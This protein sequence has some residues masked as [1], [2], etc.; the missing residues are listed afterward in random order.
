MGTIGGGGGGSGYVGG[1]AVSGTTTTGNGA[2]PPQSDPDY[3]VG[4]AV[5]GLVAGN[6]GP[7][8]VVIVYY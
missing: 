4:A 6:G 1:L 7:G 8:L 5:G 2:T 3:Q